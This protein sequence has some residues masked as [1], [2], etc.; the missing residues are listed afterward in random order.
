MENNSTKTNS[1]LL[2]ISN[3]S[4]GYPS[5]KSFRNVLDRLSVDIDKG[6][7]VA[8]VGPSGSGKTT[9]LNIIG[10]LDKADSG[11]VFFEGVDI[12]T[13]DANELPFPEPKNWHGVSASPLVAAM[14]PV[15][16]CAI[17]RAA[18]KIMECRC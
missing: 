3:I 12:T 13:M 11:Q 4:K 16:K 5:G 1:T 17:A 8:I 10:T 15:G 6:E 7:T 9:L 2:S 18:S 14:Y